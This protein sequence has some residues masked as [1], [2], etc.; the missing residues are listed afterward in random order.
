MKLYKIITSF[1]SK[2]IVQNA[3]QYIENQRRCRD[4]LDTAFN[5]DEP[6]NTM[7]EG[8]RMIL[9]PCGSVLEKRENDFVVVGIDENFVWSQNSLKETQKFKE[10][11]SFKIIERQCKR[12]A[13]QTALSYLRNWSLEDAKKILQDKIDSH[14]EYLS[15]QKL[16][17]DY[18]TQNFEPNQNKYDRIKLNEESEIEPL[19]H[20]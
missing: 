11:T 12:D 6:I 3:E 2:G 4:S 5:I 20:S 15:S 9:M 19:G 14:N 16:H 8:E 10:N 1:T 13:Y 17:Y 18:G 7:V